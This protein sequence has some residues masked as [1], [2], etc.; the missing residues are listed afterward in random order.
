MDWVYH[1]SHGRGLIRKVGSVI[2]S[3]IYTFNVSSKRYCWLSSMLN[4]RDVTIESPNHPCHRLWQAHRFQQSMLPGVHCL[5]ASSYLGWLWSA[6]FSLKFDH[7]GE[8]HHSLLLFSVAENIRTSPSG[9]GLL[10][11]ALLYTF[12]LE[13]SS[14]SRRAYDFHQRR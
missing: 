12:T 7:G 2:S 3:S 6:S 9:I 14:T 4:G 5:T 1:G 10:T 13:S 11:T 8:P